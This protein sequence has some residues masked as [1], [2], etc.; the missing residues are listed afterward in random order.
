[1]PVMNN[2]YVH[3]PFKLADAK[4]VQA[5]STPVTGTKKTSA[6]KLCFIYERV[7]E[8]VVSLGSQPGVCG[9]ESRRAYALVV[10]IAAHIVG[11]DVDLGQNQARA[12]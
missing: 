7:E 9:F 6:Q 12:P 10:I 5:G 3:Q 2:G 8:L 1:M 11:N 4:S